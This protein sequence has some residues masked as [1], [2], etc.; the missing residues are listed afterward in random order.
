MEPLTFIFIGRSGCGKGTQVKLLQ[1]YLVE[2]DTSGRDIFYLET[3]ARFR[4]FIAKDSHTSM[5]SKK[6]NE[7]GAL[8]PEFLAV[9]TWADEF[10]ENYSG[11][12][13]VIIDGTPRKIREAHV[14]DG[15]IRFYNLKQPHVIY[16]DI[17]REE[18]KKR[19]M[20]RGRAD[21]R[22]ES[23]VEKRLNWFDTDVVPVIEFF[24]D[25]SYY[26]F[27]SIV[28]EQSVEDIHKEVIKKVFGGIPNDIL[29]ID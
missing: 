12:E 28:G 29:K 2:H 24:R 22:E 10:V 7:E 9:R 25:N 17:S 26:N 6:I 8:Q 13:H 5:L 11:K 3:G 16:L 20:K 19:L 23:D 21:D 15:A 14:L 1:D 4:E 27:T 18:S